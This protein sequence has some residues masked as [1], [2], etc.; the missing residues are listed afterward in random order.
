[1][2]SFFLVNRTGAAHGDVVWKII[3]LASPSL[4]KV[5][6]A[7]RSVLE[8]GVGNMGWVLGSWDQ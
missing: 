3:P 7:V 8:R 6:S 1:L 2:P 4:I 5:S